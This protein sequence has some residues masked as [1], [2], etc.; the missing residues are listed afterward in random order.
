[1]HA[2]D[3]SAVR[4]F[5]AGA[6]ECA[7]HPRESRWSMG[8]Q[9]L[10]A[11]SRRSPI[12][13]WSRWRSMRLSKSQ[14]ASFIIYR[15]SFVFLYFL[16][17]FF[18]N[19]NSD[20]SCFFFLSFFLRR[21]SVSS[22]LGLQVICR[23]HSHKVEALRRRAGG[24]SPLISNAELAERLQVGRCSRCVCVREAGAVS[25]SQRGGGPEMAESNG[26]VHNNNNGGGW[27]WTC[28]KNNQWVSW[29]FSPWPLHDL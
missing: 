5:S 1:M 27:K 20:F 6:A 19:Q 16:F 8:C 26:R 4:V 24:G 11:E 25:G 23:L 28:V 13:W 9:T 3:Q 14:T 12:S 21:P 17:F 15:H 7:A 18:Q 22:S 10:S 29:K 2:T